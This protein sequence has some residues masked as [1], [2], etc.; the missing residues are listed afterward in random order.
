MGTG[1]GSNQT[2]AQPPGGD[3]VKQL[4]TITD[5]T[6]DILAELDNLAETAAGLGMMDMAG[7]MK[8]AAAAQTKA[9][10]LA[11]LQVR[12]MREVTDRLGELEAR[13]HA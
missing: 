6:A 10:E 13:G 1:I 2:A 4:E 11:A 5:Q 12:F 9:R 7:K 8:A 3:D